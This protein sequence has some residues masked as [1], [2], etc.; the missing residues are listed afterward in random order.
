MFLFSGTT[1]FLFLLLSMVSKNN[2]KNNRILF[3]MIINNDFS[4]TADVIKNK[5]LYINY[6][7]IIYVI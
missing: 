6:I 2:N 5:T 1:D 3:R 7:S 4:G